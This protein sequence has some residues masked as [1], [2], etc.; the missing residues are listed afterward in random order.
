ML[1][2][3]AMYFLYNTAKKNKET[4][5]QQNGP[6]TLSIIRLREIKRECQ[7]HRPCTFSII[8][9][10][11]IKRRN[12][13]N[14]EHVLSLQHGKEKQRMPTPWTIIILC[15][16]SYNK[17]KSLEDDVTILLR[18]HLYQQRASRSSRQRA[19]NSHQL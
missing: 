3:W 4:E 10:R 6:C 17:A 8:R 14:T 11:S 12:V 13:N 2:K 16:L 18:L 19:L 15:F 5:C 9:Q 1:T 7:Q